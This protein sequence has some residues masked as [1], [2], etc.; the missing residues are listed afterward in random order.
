MTWNVAGINF[1]HFHMG[2]QLGYVADHPE[3]EIVAICDEDPEE[4]T[5]SL[6]TTAA[7]FDLAEEQVYRDHERCLAENDVDL[8]ITCPV[9]TEHAE[10]VEKLAPHDVHIQL[11]KPFATSVED[12]DRAIAAV[13]GS[14]SELAVNWPLAWYPTH[15]TTKR[16]VDE[17]RI[18]DVIEVH[19]YD[20][21][22][23][24]Q[25]FT[26]VTYDDS[27]GMHFTGDIDGGGPVENV[28]P[29]QRDGSAW[30]HSAEHGGGSLTDYVGYGTTLGTWF[31]DGE[32]P[33]SVTADTYV[34][35]HMDVDTHC[36]A[37]AKYEDGLSKFET[38]WG[39]FTDPW[40]DQPQPRCGFVL[41]GT[42]GTIASYDYAETVHVQDE[43]TPSGYE[44]EVDELAPPRQNPVQYMI[45]RIE[46]VE[47]V[48]FGPLRPDL[49]RDA[50]R[51][52][53]AAAESAA[54]GEKVF[55]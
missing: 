37:V 13:E 31:R 30:W 36:I 7:E 49:C 16:L 47:P 33:I 1:A 2:D 50:Q 22:R 21:N 39:T 11:E 28:E 10:W 3:A 27:G 8:V 46:T 40:V 53:D 45:D 34:P 6:E 12:C 20:G 25:R 41:V 54:A 38:R 17:G 26:E 51:I 48:D 32:L 24:G 29:R 23:G 55:L 42:E 43:E 19:Y 9:P 5:L 44:V 14:D 15:R 4:A 18:G 52:N 35:D